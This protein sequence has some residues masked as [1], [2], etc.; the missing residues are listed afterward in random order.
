MAKKTRAKAAAASVTLNIGEIVHNDFNGAFGRLLSIRNIPAFVRLKLV[1]IAKVIQT[2]QKAI[3]DIR[4]ETL[5][6]YAECDDKG[7]PKI[8]E[9]GV[10]FVWKSDKDKESFHEEWGEV[11]DGDVTVAMGLLNIEDLNKLDISPQ[12]LL[13]LEP[14]FSD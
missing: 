10:N 6:K 14:I 3:S 8:Q 13:Q 11:L 2:E 1:K 5:N 4:L 9:D 7:N 12:E